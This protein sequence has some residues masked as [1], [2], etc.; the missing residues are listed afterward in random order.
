MRHILTKFYFL[1]TLL[2]FKDYIGITLTL[3][4]LNIH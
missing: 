2:Q 3:A 4:Y 1:V